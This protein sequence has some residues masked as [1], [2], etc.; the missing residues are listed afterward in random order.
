MSNLRICWTC[1]KRELPRSLGNWSLAR[2]HTSET[3]YHSQDL[4]SQLEV[5]S[6]RAHAWNAPERDNAL[7]NLHPS[8]KVQD[9]TDVSQGNVRC[10]HRAHTRL[11]PSQLVV[12]LLAPSQRRTEKRRGS[13]LGDE[14][15]QEGEADRCDV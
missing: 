7:C 9:P 11:T 12:V 10:V 3:V 5:L 6:R 15:V 8:T 1:E 14:P 4:R 13:V 2:R